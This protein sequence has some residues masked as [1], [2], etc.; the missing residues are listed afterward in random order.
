MLLIQSTKNVKELAERLERQRVFDILIQNRNIS[1]YFLMNVIELFSIDKLL[2]KVEATS[3]AADFKIENE[4][5]KIL[6]KHGNEQLLQFFLKRSGGLF[7]NLRQEYNFVDFLG[8]ALANFNE[9][10]A[11]ALLKTFEVNASRNGR[12]DCMRVLKAFFELEY[13][14]T[15]YKLN[16]YIND[17]DS[18][19]YSSYE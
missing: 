16:E 8:I 1:S 6:C 3:E 10:T 7:E 9:T 5:L 12:G 15:R 4:S 17:E 11:M 13:S 19:E 2:Y 18:L 14:E